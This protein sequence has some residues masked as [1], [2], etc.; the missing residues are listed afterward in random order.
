MLAVYHYTTG[1]KAERSICVHDSKMISETYSILRIFSRLGC[2]NACF[3]VF[4]Q[5]IDTGEK[6]M[7]SGSGYGVNGGLKTRKVG[8]RYWVTSAR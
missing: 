2:Y 8:R 1:S 4:L 6:F 7:V 5:C 3:T